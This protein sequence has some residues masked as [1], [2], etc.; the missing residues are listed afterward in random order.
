MNRPLVS[1]IIPAFNGERFLG[2]AIR[3]AIAQTVG[4]PDIIVV[5]DGSTD[6]TAAVAKSFGR[7]VTYL[8][9]DNAGPAAARNRGV[10]AA[11]GTFISFLD[12][13][14]LWEPDKLEKQLARFSAR[15]ELSYC[16]GMVQ[17]FWEDEVADE[18]ELMS[19][20]PRA[21]PIAGYVTMTLLVTREWMDRVG[22][23]DI[24]LGHGDAADWFQRADAMGA[25]SE[26]LPDVLGRRRLHRD[27]RSRTMAAGSRD[28]FLMMLKRR[29]DA[30]RKAGS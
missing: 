28:E 29:L 20:H 4:D 8:H 25:V 30:G 18:A 23:F 5:D 13:D 16:V 17:N 26:L 12:A 7:R 15:D 27:N 2:E 6:G 3:S 11:R 1:C 19:S 21:R 22:A 10:A 9:Q 24:T 14:D